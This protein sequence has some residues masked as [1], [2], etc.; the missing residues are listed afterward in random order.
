[1]TD[2]RQRIVPTPPVRAALEE[3][4][5]GYY[6]S[7][8]KAQDYLKQRGIT[9]QM[10]QQFRLGYVE[11]PAPGHEQ[12]RGK[13]SIPY[14]TRAGVS[15]IRFRAIDGSKP[16]YLSLPGDTPRLYNPEA[17]FDTLPYICICEGELDAITMHAA[18]GI[19]AVG[20]PGA[21]AWRDYF[22]PAFNGYTQVFIAADTDDDGAGMKFAEKV[23][24]AIRNALIT[25]MPDGHD[26]NSYFLAA[27]AAGV[28]ERL[29]L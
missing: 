14:L 4:S 25:P 16:K 21:S 2:D 5:L 11:T 6:A 17:L 23:S 12:Y 29:G 7:V 19:P 10:A 24:K 18:C 26:V 28:R 3:A 22:A 9:G 27:G 20:I 15:T 13:L 1:M 8:V